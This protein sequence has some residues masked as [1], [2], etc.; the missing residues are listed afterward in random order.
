MR[1]GGL[2]LFVAL[3]VNTSVQA[4]TPLARLVLGP[5]SDVVGALLEQSSKAVR[6]YD[7]RASEERSFPPADVLKIQQPLS[8]DQAAKYVG[9]SPL[10]AYRVKEVKNKP[11]HAASTKAKVAQATP[12]AV[13]VTMGSEQGITVGQT[14]RVYQPGTEIKD[15]DT[16]KVLARERNKVADLEV[17]EV[18]ENLSKAKLVGN[19][20]AA[21]KPGD[22]VEGDVGKFRVALLPLTNEAGEQTLIG[23]S[24]YDELAN[25]LRTQKIA[26]VERSEVDAALPGKPLGSLFEPQPAQTLGKQLG[27]SV[28]L[29]GKVVPVEGQV[30]AHLRLIDVASGELL[31]S[32]SGAAKESIEGTDVVAR[33][34]DPATLREMIAQ[35]R[36]ARLGDRKQLIGQLGDTKSPIAAKFLADEGLLLDPFA[37]EEA[38][39]AMGPVAF[40]PLIKAIESRDFIKSNKAMRVFSK[41]ATKKHIKYLQKLSRNIHF[42][43]EAQRAIARLQGNN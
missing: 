42:R 40:E 24:V 39:I 31:L 25:A 9:L 4:E 29:A 20:S 38:L 10:A 15:P 27:A 8:D 37:A 36:D 1:R 18:A 3:L 5:N 23:N 13:Y 41:V 16:G 30:S 12:S 26:I 17:F 19:S 34:V 33:P 2:A 6:V 14:L 7:L 35:C 21:L 22:E 28:V 11:G 43:T 32:V